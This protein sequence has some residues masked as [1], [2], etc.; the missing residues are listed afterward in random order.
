MFTMF[1]GELNLCPDRFAET[2]TSH[3]QSELSKR[4][5]ETVLCKDVRIP[6]WKQACEFECHPL[7]YQLATIRASTHCWDSKPSQTF[8]PHTKKYLRRLVNVIKPP[9]HL[10]GAEGRLPSEAACYFLPLF[11]LGWWRAPFS[12]Y[13]SV[14]ASGP[15]RNKKSRGGWDIFSVVTPTF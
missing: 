13:F 11:R 4:H 8:S 7:Y 12:W 14:L 6:T 5:L 10:G 15:R 3:L 1:V 9:R 2:P